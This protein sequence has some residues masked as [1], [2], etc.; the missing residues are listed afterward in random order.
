MAVSLRRRAAPFTA[1]PKADP[2]H[3]LLSV[4]DGIGV[5]SIEG[6]IL[7][8]PDLSVVRSDEGDASLPPGYR[9]RGT[10]EI[11]HCRWCPDGDAEKLQHPCIHGGHSL[12][13]LEWSVGNRVEAR[14]A[15]TRD[16]GQHEA[17]ATCSTTGSRTRAS[18]ADGATGEAS[19]PAE[20]RKDEHLTPS[21][22]V[23]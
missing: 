16:A 8:K 9:G 13:S 1:Q 11:V 21:S 3:P 4:E 12:P 6:P 5:V 14:A 2:P 22:R 17:S 20:P 10:A 15:R 18:K 23:R 19:Q 7:R